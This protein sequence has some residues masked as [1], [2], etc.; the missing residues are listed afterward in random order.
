MPD[1][2]LL[3]SSFFA[4]AICAA[5][6]CFAALPR[7]GRTG[8]GTGAGPQ[9]AAVGGFAVGVLAGM[10]TQGIAPALPPA[11]GLDRWLLIAIP[12]LLV[13]DAACFAALFRQQ[14]RLL[15]LAAAATAAPVILFGSVHLQVTPELTLLPGL[16]LGGLLTVMAACGTL[17]AVT[18]LADRGSEVSMVWRASG[19]LL[20]LQAAG[21]TVM[22]GGWIRGGAAALPFSGSCAGILLCGLTLRQ[23]ATAAVINRWACWS[24]SGVVLLGHFFGRL[25]LLQSGLLIFGAVLPPLVPL[26]NGLKSG[27]IRLVVCC[28]LTLV[29]LA[30]VLVPAVVDFFVRMR[31]LLSATAADFIEAR[32][33]QILVV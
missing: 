29:T 5:A 16:T 25:S 18:M 27:R 4:S 6:A 22:L 23:P 33:A 9:L 12:L 8:S 28:L 2:W 10:A 13:V 31:P 30:T 14:T 26:P 19:S 21:M 15:R 7:S 32:H 11:S 1:L 20:V 17:A 24:L 3:T